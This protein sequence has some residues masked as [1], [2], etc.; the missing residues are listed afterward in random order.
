MVKLLVYAHIVNSFKQS[1]I[2]NEKLLFM[3]TRIGHV[4]LG[5]SLGLEI[6]SYSL[7]NN[8]SGMS[9]LLCDKDTLDFK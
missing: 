2:L 6:V 9:T 1:L 8:T 4:F 7:G 5:Q 3:P